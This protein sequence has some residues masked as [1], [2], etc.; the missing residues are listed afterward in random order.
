[1]SDH[2]PHERDEKASDVDWI[3][4]Y[5]CRRVWT[6][7]EHTREGCPERLHRAMLEAAAELR[8]IAHEM[9]AGGSRL[10]ASVARVA[11]VL[12]GER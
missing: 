4:A 2:L 5:C 11:D 6:S 8:S 7:T 1:M 3:C 10:G 12:E 9:A